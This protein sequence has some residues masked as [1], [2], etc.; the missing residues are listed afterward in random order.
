[1][2]FRKIMWHFRGIRRGTVAAVVA[3]LALAIFVI[4]NEGKKTRESIEGAGQEIAKEVRGGIIDGVDRSI[5]KAAEVPGK[6]LRD[7]KDVLL[8]NS[9]G[10]GPDNESKTAERVR[11]DDAAQTTKADD[12]KSTEPKPDVT[13]T[14]SQ[15]DTTASASNK[16]TSQTST[17][18]EPKSVPAKSQP[19]D[20]SES[21]GKK[22]P[23]PSADLNP[24]QLIR[25]AIKLGQGVTKTVDDVGERTLGLSVAEEI[26]IGKN[27]HRNVV[28]Q[29]KVSSSS[30]ATKRLR[31]LAKP[32]LAHVE[33]QGI[34]YSFT[35]LASSEIN[36]FS[37]VGG[38]LYVNQ[39][40]LNFAMSDA[41]LQFI[42]AHE[43]A[44]VDLGHCRR[45]LAYAVRAGEWVGD[46]GAELVQQAYH[47]IS[48]G[49][50]E[51]QE[52]E[53]DESAF[54]QMLKIGRTPDEALALARHFAQHFADK[55][56]RRQTADKDRPDVVIADEIEKHLRSHPPATERVRRLEKLAD[57][58]NRG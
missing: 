53:A 38:Y 1:M 19:T 10:V 16:E 31:D 51:D 18:N 32:L 54:R 22:T 28:R 50:S 3:V 57:Q 21:T 43:I 33:R 44:H 13:T 45:G 7:V 56:E 36:A 58:L 42:L 49:N 25:E 2:C 8:P 27:V 52:F 20:S 29:H 4:Q 55:T 37:H 48:L 41:E 17:P 15:P 23:T 12:P 6:V 5:D 34:N 14:D 11:R 30:A 9:S 39:G 35:V 47:L 46:H 26:D 24:G 40:L